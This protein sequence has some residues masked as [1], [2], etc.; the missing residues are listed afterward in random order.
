MP[1]AYAILTIAKKDMI[2]KSTQNE[3]PR[4]RNLWGFLF[5][6][7]KGGLF[8]RLIAV[9]FLSVQPF[10]DKIKSIYDITDK[11]RAEMLSR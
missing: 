10:A 4:G 1:T 11:K 9:L 2:V 3:T 8:P 6:F 5:R 7:G